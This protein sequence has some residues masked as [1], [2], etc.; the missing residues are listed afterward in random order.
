MDEDAERYAAACRQ[1][2]VV[3]G[4]VGDSWDRPSPCTEWDARGVLE[5][6]IGFNDVL[7]LRPSGAK[8]E[9]PKGDP[10]ARW[11]VTEVAIFG[12]IG[13]ADDAGRAVSGKDGNETGSDRGAAADDGGGGEGGAVDLARLL[14]VLTVDVLAH[15]WDLSRAAGIVVPVDPELCRSAYET[16]RPNAERLRGSGMFADPFPIPEDA[17]PLDRLVAFLGRD[18]QWT[19]G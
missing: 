8:P 5:H 2:S 13:A 11:A 1:F 3:V 14:P 17:D 19:P 10:I 9:R 12:V 4:R 16:V 6:V 7:L 15:A 18:P